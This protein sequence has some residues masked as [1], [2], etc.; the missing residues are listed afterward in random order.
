MKKYLLLLTAFP[1]L[2]CCGNDK[3]PSPESKAIETATL[4]CW[5]ENWSQQKGY[6]IS[7]GITLL[8]DYLFSQGLLG[9]RT[10]EDYRKFFNDTTVIFISDSVK[11][12]KEMSMALNSDYE[13]A[14]NVEGMIKC[15]ET[16]WFSKISTLDTSDVLVNTGNLVQMLSKS[17]NPEYNKV[18]TTFFTGLTEEEFNRPLI[19]DIAY[20]I[21]WKTRERKTH[22]QFYHSAGGDVGPPP[23]PG[24]ENP[25]GKSF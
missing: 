3:G 6:D 15:W 5:N 10:V 9:K 2:I 23:P 20:F 18:L 14:P 7:K 19:K 1:F 4:N 22:I 8:D 16:N 21:F 11:G 24:P 25:A 13:G 12:N 17:G